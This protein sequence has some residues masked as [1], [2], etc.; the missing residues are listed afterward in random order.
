MRLY[1]NGGHALVTG[2]LFLLICS[3]IMGCAV[4]ITR[5]KLLKQMQEGTA[6]LIV[7]VRTQGEYDRDHVPGAIHI[8]FYAIGSALKARNVSKKEP[9][10]LYC[11]HGPR[12]DVSSFTLFLEGYEKVFSLEGSMKGWRKSR[13]PIEIIVRGSSS[14]LPEKALRT[15]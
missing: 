10:I 7:D 15:R 4:G 11:E 2:A 9:L 6:P 12:A 13:F 14:P 1:R 3:G 8:P 5:D